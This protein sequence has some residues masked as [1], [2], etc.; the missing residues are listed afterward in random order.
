MYTKDYIQATYELLEHD[1]HG[2]KTLTSL[3]AYLKKRGLLAL[4]PSILRG[5]AEKISRKNKSTIPKVIVAHEHDLKKY[6][7]EIDDFI[8]EYGNGSKPEVH[9]DTSIIGGFILK[10][11]D[12]YIDQSYKNKLLHAYRSLTD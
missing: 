8:T 4:Y 12:T 2:E 10:S 1:T 3:K 9:V 6:S 5:L 7:K 11:K